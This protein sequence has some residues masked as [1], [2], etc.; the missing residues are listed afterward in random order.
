MTNQ[1]V[2][3]ELWASTFPLHWQTMQ[4]N[5]QHA[6]QHFAMLVPANQV[7]QTGMQNHVPQTQPQMQ[8]TG[9]GPYMIQG[10]GNSLLN[11]AHTQP[12]SECSHEAS[13]KEASTQT[14]HKSQSGGKGE[15]EKE[16]REG[17]QQASKKGRKKGKGPT[18]EN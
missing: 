2:D 13:R 9:T 12:H 15:G 17:R 16:R 6:P 3:Q 18:T 14:R 5:Y 7:L 10:T 11:P 8:G 4:M 1:Q